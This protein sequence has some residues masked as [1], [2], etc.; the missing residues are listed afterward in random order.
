MRVSNHSSN[1][2]GNEIAKDLK[3]LNIG[4]FERHCH[5]FSTSCRSQ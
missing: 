2:F 4:D 3:I 5:P 1:L